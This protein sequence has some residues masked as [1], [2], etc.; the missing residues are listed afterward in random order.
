MSDSSHSHLQAAADKLSNDLK[1]RECP[2]FVGALGRQTKGGK[3]LCINDGEIP[4]DASLFGDKTQISVGLIV[5]D[6]LMEGY[7]K[8]PYE[9]VSGDKYKVG[10]NPLPLSEVVSWPDDP[11]GNLRMLRCWPY[12][13]LNCPKDKDDRNEEYKWEV[14]LCL[15]LS[16]INVVH[17][18]CCVSGVSR[19]A[20]PCLVLAGF[21]A[22]RG[23][24]QV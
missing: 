14:S 7:T 12:G 1:L 10:K 17:S 2:A 13:I 11:T 9:C 6:C 3:L 15:C 24:P 22:W 18:D 20:D 5:V 23:C 8:V 21:F 4:L 19:Q 16:G